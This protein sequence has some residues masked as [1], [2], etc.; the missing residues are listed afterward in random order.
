MSSDA[1]AN[2]NGTDAIDPYDWSDIGPRYAGLRE[3][4]LVPEDVPGWLA[5]WSDSRSRCGRHGPP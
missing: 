4:D 1:S 2:P 5:R 3:A